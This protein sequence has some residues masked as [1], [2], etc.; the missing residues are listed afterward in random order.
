MRGPTASLS[1]SSGQGTLLRSTS[2]LPS[3]CTCRQM[4]AAITC[5]DAS[6]TWREKETKIRDQHTHLGLVESLHGF[7]VGSK[8]LQRVSGDAGRIVQRLV[9]LIVKEHLGQARPVCPREKQ[10]LS[11][12][13]E[14]APALLAQPHHL[15]LGVLRDE[16]RLEA[17]I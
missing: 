16:K 2:V 12:H 6:T 4:P 15:R 10:A 1:S 9:P 17:K 11:L 7:E 5:T 3:G 13:Q 8:V 14:A